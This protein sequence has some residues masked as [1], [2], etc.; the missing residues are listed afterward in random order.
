MYPKALSLPPDRLVPN[1]WNTNHVSPENEAKLTASIRR[2]GLI[3]SIVVRENGKDLEI[4]SGEHRVQICVQLKVPLIP[5]L[6]LGPISED[7]AKQIGLVLNERYGSDDAIELAELLKGFGDGFD[8][9]E[10]LPWSND[11]ITQIFSSVDIALDKLDLD[12]GESESDATSDPEEP[13][14][15]AAPKTHRVMRFQVPEGDADKLA[16]LI[17]RTQKR[18]GFTAGSELQNAG[19]ALVHLL[20]GKTAPATVDFPD[21]LDA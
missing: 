6:N 7:E 4:L 16:E 3:E 13:K 2:L 20:L 5:V 19:D 9:Q 21:A 1:S 17:A 14:L 15:P 10:I 18:Q 8:F 11:D 12:A